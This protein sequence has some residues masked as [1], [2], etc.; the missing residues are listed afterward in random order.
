MLTRPVGFARLAIFVGVV[1]VVA[2]ADVEPPIFN[3][4]KILGYF[5]FSGRSIYSLNYSW[6]IKFYSS[7]I[8]C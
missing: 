1:V 4:I 8:F 3:L 5:R 6:H 2:A 7:K